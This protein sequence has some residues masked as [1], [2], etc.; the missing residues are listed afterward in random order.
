M[1]QGYIYNYVKFFVCCYI[2]VEDRG[3]M[4]EYILKLFDVNEYKLY[5]L[6]MG[7]FVIYCFDL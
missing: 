7:F 4:F 2:F 5:C 6:K 1:L 3:N